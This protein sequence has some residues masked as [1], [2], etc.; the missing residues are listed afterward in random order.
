MLQYL[1]PIS[2]VLIAMGTLWIIYNF[3]M[4]NTNFNIT[5]TLGFLL[6]SVSM[7]V[8]SYMGIRKKP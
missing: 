5:Y 1:R 4:E 8:Y 7:L 3:A 2:L 6:F